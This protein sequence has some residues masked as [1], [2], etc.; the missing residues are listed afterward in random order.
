M[1]HDFTCSVS[2]LTSSAGSIHLF[3]YVNSLDS[4]TNLV[5]RHVTR[6]CETVPV[7]TQYN[8][9]QTRSKLVTTGRTRVF[10]WIHMK[11][12][13]GGA[14][15]IMNQYDTYQLVQKWFLVCWVELPLPLNGSP[16]RVLTIHLFHNLSFSMDLFKLWGVWYVTVLT[17]RWCTMTVQYSRITTS[18]VSSNWWRTTN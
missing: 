15:P 12:R 14:V 17:W 11:T 9:C 16:P 5:C 2:E 1:T 10:T 7:L 4:V 6:T 8:L 3:P 18:A 13:T